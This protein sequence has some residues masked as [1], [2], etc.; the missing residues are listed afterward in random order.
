M[1][2]K[3]ESWGTWVARSVKHWTLEFNSGRD[4]G[5]VGS[6][7]DQ[8]E[9]KEESAGDSLSLSPPAPLP[10]PALALS[11]AVSKTNK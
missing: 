9:L 1:A 2:V 8:K 11:P 10:A 5:V 3:M 7:G 4:L 6:R